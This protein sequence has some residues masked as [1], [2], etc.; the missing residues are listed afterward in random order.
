MLLLLGFS[1]T[2][3][4]AAT[5][6]TGGSV[7]NVDSIIDLAG[8]KPSEAYYQVSWHQKI[9]HINEHKQQMDR[10]ASHTTGMAI[11]GN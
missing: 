5:V 6:D 2:Y 8:Y 3:T 11:R 9:I 7:S 4:S 1:Q 10:V